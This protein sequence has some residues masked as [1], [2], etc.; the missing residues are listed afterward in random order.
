MI[1]S[2][3]FH[4]NR[5]CSI[6]IP[7]LTTVKNVRPEYIYVAINFVIELLGRISPFLLVKLCVFIV[8]SSYVACAYECQG[9]QKA[10]HTATNV[11]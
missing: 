1:Y 4:G 2:N 6:T 11:L 10:N 8:N 5:V 9:S 3:M 7:E